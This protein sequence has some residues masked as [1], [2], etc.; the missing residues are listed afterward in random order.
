MAGTDALQDIRYM[1]RALEL[2]R[3][4]LGR[5]SPNPAV[6]ALVV[7]P[8]GTIAGRGYHAAAGTAHAEVLALE[9][10]GPRARGATLYVTLE[11]CCHHGR[12][13]P[14]TDAIQR[15][16]V[17]RV[18]AAMLDPD[19]RVSGRGA[20]ALRRAGVA[21]DVGVLEHQAG[22][23][24]EAYVHHR[25]TGL[26]FVTMKV[27]MTL[28]GKVA[29]RAG[30]ARWISGEDS[31]RTVHALRGEV[32]AVLVGVGTVLA[33]DPLLTAR[34][35]GR[36]ASAGGPAPAGGPASAGRA[37]RQP[38]RV[39]ADSA[40]RTPPAARVLA[41]AGNP[42]RTLI[43]VTPGA[44]A[45]RVRALEAAGAE[46][47]RLPAEA[48]GR[49]D[50]RALARELGRRGVLHVLLEG[51]PTLNAAALAA[52]L[53]QKVLVFVAPRIVGGAAAP[54]PVGGGGAAR[55]ADAIPVRSFA[56]RRSGEDVL[57]EGY[58]APSAPPAPAGTPAS[59]EGS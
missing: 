14:C 40:A 55:L 37:P 36:P 26:P 19:P 21:V 53:V 35:A 11:P 30:D 25:R 58:V 16:G 27:A 29:T 12:T 18:V 20:A 59:E 17:A 23:L 47:L 51:G 15:A 42:R 38:L 6:G 3:R 7:A 5:T 48:D 2:A 46:V 4:G 24:L 28:D 54:G 57:L 32:D 1:R 50:L 45:A 8:D 49:V 34:P 39:I 43:A 52:G 56:A 9:E 33:D 31:R 22:R 10:A 41:S 44:P 13:P